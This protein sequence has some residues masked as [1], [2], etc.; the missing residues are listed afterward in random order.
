MHDQ[1]R[2]DHDDRGLGMRE[3]RELDG[4]KV[5]SLRAANKAGLFSEAA[6]PSPSVGI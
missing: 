3:G 2:T 1:I 6:M 5:D 4:R